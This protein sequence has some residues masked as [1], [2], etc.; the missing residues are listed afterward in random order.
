LDAC[1][2]K[3]ELD[4]KNATASC[5]LEL[6]SVYVVV[7]TRSCRGD[8]RNCW[9][10]M[11]AEF[12]QFIADLKLVGTLADTKQPQRWSEAGRVAYD[13]VY[14]RLFPNLYAYCERTL[15]GQKG[16]A[17]HDTEDLFILAFN[18]L[19]SGL[20]RIRISDAKDPAGLEKLLFCCFSRC[21]DWTLQDVRR[22]ES[23]GDLS[24]IFAEAVGTRKRWR[25]QPPPRGYL[26]R[27]QKLQELLKDLSAKDRDILV[28]AFT[29]QD[30]L[31][32]IIEWPAEE[33]ARLCRE[34]NFR[35]PNALNQYRRRKFEE[36]KTAMESVA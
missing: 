22:D 10:R 24:E 9:R 3:T 12:S 30:A 6:L 18:K 27:K 15:T 28:T 2:I 1:T 20:S 19:V 13:R 11:D 14:R 4:D 31:T 23:L 8:L 26:A 32:G 33:R 35:T 25:G 5:S 36:L 34:Y 21:L 17:G 29:H 7:A 16:L